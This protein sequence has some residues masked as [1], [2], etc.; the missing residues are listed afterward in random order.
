[1]IRII[2]HA[3]HRSDVNFFMLPLQGHKS[4]CGFLEIMPVPA[5][6]RNHGAEKN[7]RAGWLAEN[8]RPVTKSV[9]K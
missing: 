7:G 9:N 3:D 1:M 5:K 8:V 2:V 6:F 4:I